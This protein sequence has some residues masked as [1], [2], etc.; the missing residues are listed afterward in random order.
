M[1]IVCIEIC[2]EV[3]N[4]QMKLID[5]ESKLRQFNVLIKSYEFI[6]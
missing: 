2:I 5:R 3:I 1:K 4:Y 6:R